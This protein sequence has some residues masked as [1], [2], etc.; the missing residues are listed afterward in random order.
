VADSPLAFVNHGDAAREKLFLE[1]QEY[2]LSPAVQQ[3]IMGHGR[4]V[5]LGGMEMA[6]A[7][8]SLF[9]PAW[10]IDLNRVLAPIRYPQADVIREAL[11]LYQT[12]FRKPSFTVYCLDYSG[13]M[14]GERIS[15]LKTAMRTLLDQDEARKQL[16]QASAADVTVVIPFTDRPQDEWAV[17][18]N[19][20][21][22]LDGLLQHINQAEAGG[23]TNIYTPVERALELFKKKSNLE[24]YFPAVILMTDGQSNPGYDFSQFQARRRAVNLNWDVP[25]FS[26]RFGEASDEQLQELA[27][28]TSGRVFDG[29]RDL[30]AAFREARGYN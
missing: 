21:Q 15:Q 29:R 8:R 19:S 27:Q 13:S 24:D 3:E 18:G 4:R 16:L 12:A 14:Q 23:G 10:G 28:A 17:T 20:P 6:G 5:G 30:V 1:L 22:Q 7:D 11:D 9:N 26:I 2:L 25:V